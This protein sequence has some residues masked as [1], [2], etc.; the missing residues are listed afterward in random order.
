MLDCKFL[1]SFWSSCWNL[2]DR[3]THRWFGNWLCS[4]SNSSSRKFLAHWL[5]LGCATDSLLACK[6][7]GGSSSVLLER[8][9][10]RGNNLCNFFFGKRS[11][12]S[13]CSYFKSLSLISRFTQLCSWLCHSLLLSNN[14]L[15]NC[16]KFSKRLLNSLAHNLFNLLFRI[17]SSFLNEISID[18][19]SVSSRLSNHTLVLNL[20]LCN[21]LLSPL[22]DELGIFL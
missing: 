2:G 17:S 8:L 13:S 12:S 9:F 1:V 22:F 3:L 16:L 10:L 11:S 5:N 21:L 18:R 4:D 6:L 14:R 7:F 20:L 19:I 15:C